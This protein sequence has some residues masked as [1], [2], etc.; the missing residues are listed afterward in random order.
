MPYCTIE[1]AWKQSLNPEIEK[2]QSDEK[3]TNLGYSE[4]QLNDSELHNTNGDS[5][6]KV[7]KKVKKRNRTPNM[8]RTY[9]RLSEHNGPKTRL[10]DSNKMRHVRNESRQ[11]L[12]NSENHPSYNNSDLPINSYNNSMYEELDDEYDKTSNIDKS[13]M[14][15]DFKNAHCVVSYNSNVLV[16]SVCEGIPI[17]ALSNESVAWEV[18]NKLHNIETLDLN[19]NRSQWLYNTAYMVWTEDEILNGDA[20][21]HLKG[22]YFK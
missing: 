10:K 2:D 18:S 20:W 8:S 7:K 4:I 19:I 13:S 11:E 22:V 14:L 5:I 21:N 1:E 17:I 3:S 12:D 6:R 9:N 16:E 15:E